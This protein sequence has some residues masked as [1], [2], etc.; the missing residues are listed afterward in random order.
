MYWGYYTMHISTHLSLPSLGWR[1]FFQQQLSLDDLENLTVGRVTAQHKSRYEVRTSEAFIHADHHPDLTS[2]TVGDWL[3]LDAHGRIV[4]ILDRLTELS[5]KAPGSRAEIQLIGANIDTLFIVSS[6]NQDFSLN[7]L[8]RYLSIAKQSG[9]E[10]VI[11]LTKMDL[12]QAPEEYRNQVMQLD[13]FLAVEMVNARDKQVHTQLSQ[14][15]ND[16]NTIAIMGSSGVGK[17]TLINTL[18]GRQEQATGAIREDDGK[19]RHTTTSRQLFWLPGGGMVIDTPGMRELQ[20]ANCEDGVAEAFADISELAQGCRFT[21]CQ[22]Q[23]EPG[24]KVLAALS[25][26]QID[27]RR[28][29]NYHKLLREQARNSQSLAQVRKSEKSFSKLIRATISDKQSR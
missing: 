23:T 16:G 12:A 27:E 20:L 21:D 25:A 6:M 3:L 28:L 18:Q 22:H 2:V 8:E 24:C 9:C 5:R 7:R 11:I 14:W 1:N 17:S 26:G 29:D 15:C 19:G 13:P 4:R 10:P